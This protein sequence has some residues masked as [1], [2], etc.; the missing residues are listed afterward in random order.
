MSCL[1]GRKSRLLMSALFGC[2]FLLYVRLDEE[3]DDSEPEVTKLYLADAPAK[4]VL[5]KVGKDLI[6]KV[7]LPAS[8]NASEELHARLASR[9]R[10]VKEVCHR[11]DLDQP[12]ADY[13]VNA[14]E[15]FINY[16]YNLIWC[17]VFKAASS[18]W[19]WNFNMLAGYSERE[20]LASKIAPVE[21]ARQRYPRPTV[22]QLHQA[23]NFKPQPL[24][25]MITKN[26]LLRLVSAYRNKIQNGNAIY[27]PL[28]SRIF[29]RY[30]KYGPPVP[31][32]PKNGMSPSRVRGKYV[33]SFS[34]F[35]Q[36]VLDEEK[37]QK[38]L[39]M[40]W[41]PQSRFCTPCLV[42]FNVF[43]KT[44]TLDEDG[45]Y[46]IFTSGLNKVIKPK[47]INRSLNGSSE[48]IAKEFLCQLTDKQ[49]QGLLELYKYDL[50]LFQYESASLRTC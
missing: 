23:L 39:D 48:D 36:Y 42:N 15:F 11:Y 28:F 44:E 29:K 22:K 33:P 17:N 32:V 27:V 49:F 3:G 7:V 34:Q 43:A 4:E 12:R 47:I 20:L 46:I 18:T 37:A 40:H 21:L 14:W 5:S 41:I 24:T 6:E 8:W 13:Q 31:M 9:R 2:L 1:C 50:E 19:L 25:F 30:K 45:N 35:V 26:P 10:H 38:T 16:E